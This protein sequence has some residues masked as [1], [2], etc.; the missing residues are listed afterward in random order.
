[1]NGIGTLR[2]DSL[3]AALKAWYAQ[4]GDRLECEVDG[5]V[6]DLVRGDLLVEVQTG[7]FAAVRQKLTRLLEGHPI[8]LV[9]PIAI[10]K[11]VVRMSEDGE[12]LGRRRS[13][14]H[15]R[16]QDLF[17]EL[18]HLPGLMRHPGLT[19]EVLLTR[20][21]AIWRE[22]GKGSWRH[23]GRSKADRLLLEVVS[24]SVYSEPGDFGR[25]LPPDLAP[26]FTVPDLVER[27]GEPRRLAQKMAY[28][29]R[30]MG[31]IEVVGKRG[32]AP[33]YRLRPEG[34]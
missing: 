19:L 26:V 32:R 24:G 15:G 9:Y 17:S 13:P 18:V 1:M 21:E 5:Y 34:A 14:K 25:L 22:D 11:W 2:E 16:E 7:N 3:H 30:E 8:R 23:K 6:I 28:C 31:V 10:D 12:V 29:L 33:E 20:E 27:A 4:P